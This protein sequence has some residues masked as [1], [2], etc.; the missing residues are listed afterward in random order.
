M[1]TWQVDSRRQARPKDLRRNQT[2]RHLLT[3]RMV[4]KL[5]SIVKKQS[6]PKKTLNGKVVYFCSSSLPLCSRPPNSTDLSPLSSTVTVSLF[7]QPHGEQ[8]PALG[9]HC[10]LVLI[11]CGIR[12]VIPRLL[13]KI[14]TTSRVS[15]YCFFCNTLFVGQSGFSLRWFLL[16]RTTGSRV[17]RLPVTALRLQ[18]SQEWCTGLAAR[19]HMGSQF[20]EQES[21]V[22]PLPSNN[23]ML[24]SFKK[25][26]NSDPC[27]NTDEP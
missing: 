3:S 14:V 18:S 6:P 21:N 7:Y 16:L 12:N 17:H 27:C 5:I 23:A 25:E 13:E 26:R 19:W 2:C 20:L 4:V 24:F 1:R 10:F 8:Q 11:C 9:L 22:C 15:K